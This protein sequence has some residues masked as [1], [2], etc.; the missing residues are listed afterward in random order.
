[1]E[2]ELW[3][4]YN[5]GSDNASTFQLMEI[6][7]DKCNEGVFGIIQF[8]TILLVGWSFLLTDGDKFSLFFMNV[9]DMLL[10]KQVTIEQLPVYISFFKYAFQVFY[11]SSPSPLV[12]G[13]R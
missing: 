9:V 11:S 1:M 12:N 6:V 7:V 10:S 3:N 5:D 2:L 8:I 4:N 13:S